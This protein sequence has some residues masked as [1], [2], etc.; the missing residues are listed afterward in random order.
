V[1]DGLDVIRLCT[2]YRLDGQ[3]YTT[4]PAGAE[5]YLQCEPVYEEIPGW[6]ES[7]VGLKEYSELPGNARAYLERIQE[8]VEVPI[9][10]VSTGPDRS[11]TIVLRNPFC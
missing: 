1:L 4:P 6:K 9:D 10:I 5:E 7:T 2:G 11:E 8:L 3:L